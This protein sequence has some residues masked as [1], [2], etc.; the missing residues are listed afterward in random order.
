[1]S[2][3]QESKTVKLLPVA[4]RT[5]TRECIY[6]LSKINLMPIQV[7]PS[8]LAGLV[9]VPGRFCPHDDVALI[10]NW[11]EIN[12]Y[13]PIAS[14]NW[15]VLAKDVE[16]LLET[17]TAI[18]SDTIAPLN[19]PVLIDLSELPAWEYFQVKHQ[20]ENPGPQTKK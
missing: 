9:C 10:H 4:M 5:R 1:M 6:Q 15:M 7:S 11:N 14:G 2:L 12:F 17:N 20:I 16:A 19:V 18:S 8:Q 3:A 13:A